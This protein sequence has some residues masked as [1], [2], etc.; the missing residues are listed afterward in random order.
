MLSLKN[1]WRFWSP[2]GS[3]L[4]PTFSDVAGLGFF[5]ETNKTCVSILLGLKYLSL[6]LQG[7]KRLLKPLKEGNHY[8]DLQKQVMC[9]SCSQFER[10]KHGTSNMEHDSC[11]MLGSNPRKT[12]SEAYLISIIYNRLNVCSCFLSIFAPTSQN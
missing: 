8:R 5:P 7:K 12:S 4:R 9:Y 10:K 11:R 3:N 6:F 1:S 2:G